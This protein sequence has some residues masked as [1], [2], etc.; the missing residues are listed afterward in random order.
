MAK[1]RLLLVHWHAAEARERAARLRA[2]GYTVRV[3]WRESNGEGFKRVRE[4]PPDAVVIDLD[5]IPSHG[6]ACGVWLRQTKVTR[7]VPILYV[8]D[9]EA[10]V[11]ET[12]KLLP[13]AHFG[14]WR[15][16]RGDLRRALAAARREPPE[17]PVVPDTM[18]GYSRTPLA[19]KLT[20]REG[21]RVA[22]VGAPD[23]FESLLGPLPEGVRL[24]HTARGTHDVVILFATTCT[25]LAKRWPAAT[26]ALAEG[27]GIW[28]AWPKK[29]S[30]MAKDLGEKEVRAFGLARSFV[31][32]KICAIDPTWSGLLFTRRKR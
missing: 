2:A 30:G 3:H 12:R 25:E 22:L 27:G 10:R 16:I 28:I 9:D 14:T 4:N 21:K 6:R 19:K 29:T 11:A 7:H 8:G 23:G 26:R 1:P 20:I 13:D 32:Y 18:A 17:A 5:R 15:R 31:D 24:A